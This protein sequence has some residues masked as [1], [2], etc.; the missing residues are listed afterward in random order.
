VLRVKG[1]L[2]AAALVVLSAVVAVATVGGAGSSAATGLPAIH[3][4][5]VIILENEEGATTFGS[6]PPA[7]YLATTMRSEGVYLPNY[8]GIGHAS[9]DNYIAM[10]SGQAPNPS[11]QADCANFINFPSPGVDANL[12]ETGSGCVYPA[13]IQTLPDQLTAA[14]LTWG[15]YD[16]S[17][18]LDPGREASTCGHPPVGSAD[19]TEGGETA[20]PFDEYANR[21]NPFMY[22]HSIIDSPSCN[23]NVVNLDQLPGAL[24]SESTT[25]NYVFITPDLCGDGHDNPCKDPSRHGGYAGIN[26]FLSTWVPM[27]TASPAYK[28]GGLLITT[29]DEGEGD[30]TSCCGEVPGPTNS[31]PGGGGPGGGQVGA[32]LMSPFITP[33]TVSSTA[34]NH[35]S[36]LHSVETFFGLPPLGDAAGTTTFGSDVFGGGSTTTST[37]TTHTSTSTSTTQ[38]KTTTAPAPCVVP[39]LPRARHRKLPASALLRGISITHAKGKGTSVGFTAVRDENVVVHVKPRH[40]RSRK[41]A[42]FTASGC[43]ASDLSLPTGHGTVT[44]RAAVR[45]GAATVVKHY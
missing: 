45:S 41:L 31:A 29:F 20:A 25:P 15:A 11:T 5:F 14:G 9:L 1:R 22:F 23:T 12:Q 4:V 2:I 34:Y 24:A 38:T 3:H 28:D 35:Y 36:M 39:K 30:D 33:G 37:S 19:N 42:S 40:R 17:M 27:I 6:N 8:Y 26:D 10:I 43:Q 13:S 32:V 16:Q 44:I 18:G 7:P 21:H